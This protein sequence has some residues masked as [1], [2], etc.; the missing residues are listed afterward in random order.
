MVSQL[1]K[2]GLVSK[3]SLSS[4]RSLD[5]ASPSYFVEGLV[6]DNDTTCDHV[7]DTPMDTPLIGI[8]LNSSLVLSE[9]CNVNDCS[10][11][12]SSSRG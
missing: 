7:S 3:N 4:A 1:A 6:D 11:C 9:R 2:A 10:G 5:D 8:Q 12:F